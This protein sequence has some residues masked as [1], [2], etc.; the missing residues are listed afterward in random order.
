MSKNWLLMCIASFIGLM[1][2]APHIEGNIGVAVSA[3]ILAITM[4]MSLCL[5]AQTDEN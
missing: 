2:I 4:I 1:C 5:M 3:G